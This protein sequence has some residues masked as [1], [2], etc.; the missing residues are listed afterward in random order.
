MDHEETVRIDE[1]VPT[2]ETVPIDET[3]LIYETVHG[4]RAYGLD[5]AGSDVDLKGVIVG[6]KRW[7]FGFRGGP[8]QVE[9]AKAEGGAEGG[10]AEVEGVHFEV[11]KLLRL[12]AA[13]NPTILELFFTEPEDHRVVT[14]AGERLLA[15]REGLLTRK[16]G[17]TFGGYALGQLKR[18][19]TH[20]RW[21]LSPPSGAPK[22]EDFGLPERTLV[23]KD[24]LGAA[25]ALME[26]GA[27]GPLSGAFLEL[28]AREKRYDAAK[29]EWRQYRQWKK[30]RN[31]KRAALEKAHG[32]DTKHAMHL[33]RLQR[34][35]I[36]ILREG[37][38]RVRRADREEL[39]AI[40]DGA[41]SYEALV[42]EAERNGEAIRAAKAESALPESCDEDALEQLGVELVE[43]VL[44]GA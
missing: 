12:A 6:P 33:V 38:V 31:P 25:E 42:E 19:R 41:W 35:A 26:R 34:M 23:P 40:R 5:R 32:Y 22:R 39:L 28:L 27:D 20:R 43:D 30:K 24:Q 7:Y 9:L 10:G 15:A 29:K 18:I 37:E 11:R 21:L 8:E 17:D 4:S 14:P 3:V 13:A 36:E 2:D 44:Y 16:V 1:T